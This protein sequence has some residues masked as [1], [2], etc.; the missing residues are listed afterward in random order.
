MMKLVS[1][2]IILLM[3]FAFTHE[4][5][6]PVFSYVGHCQCASCACCKNEC[7]CKTAICNPAYQPQFS[8][9]GE[10]FFPLPLSAF[11]SFLRDNLGARYAFKLTL[12]V[13][14]PPK[15]VHS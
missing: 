13:F 2:C 15:S 10:K 5:V 14:H 8:L 12:D 4:M 9:A 1:L 11:S 3:I 6:A 7:H